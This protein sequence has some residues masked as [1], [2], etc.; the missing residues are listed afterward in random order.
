MVNEGIGS[1]QYYERYYSSRDWRFYKSILVDVLRF[2]EPGPILDVGAGTGFI[3][4]GFLRWGIDCRGIEGSKEAVDI[5]RS[6]FPETNLLQHFLSDPFPFPDQTFQT[7]IMNQV[8]EHLEPAVAE[9]SVAESYRVLRPGG[10]LYVTSPS[11]FNTYERNADPTHLNL[12]S[13]GELRTLLSEKGFLKVI[14]M[15]APLN[16]LG[17]NWVGREIMHYLFKYTHWERISAT[18]NCIAYK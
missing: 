2:S 16:L 7:V 10:I 1:Q 18:A 6:R 8:I 15:N 13:P 5:A 14:P 4:E 3:V 12:C 9:N 17:E 11:R